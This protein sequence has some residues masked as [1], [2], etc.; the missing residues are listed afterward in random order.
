MRCPE[1]SSISK[2]RCYSQWLVE[3]KI[4]T[5]RGLEILR[6]WSSTRETEAEQTTKT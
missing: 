2:T 5:V 1:N 4:G 3:E 6:D